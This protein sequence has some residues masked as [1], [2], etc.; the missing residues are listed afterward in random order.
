MRPALLHCRHFIIDIHK[1]YDWGFVLLIA[2]ATAGAL[3][4]SR[5]Q[6]ARR[7]ASHRC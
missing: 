6:I 3:A 7:S 4:V 1:S 5:I 2:M